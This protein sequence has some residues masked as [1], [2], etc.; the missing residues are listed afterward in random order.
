ML[1]R[2]V[3]SVSAVLA[4]ITAVG[5]PPV[6]A[7]H[8]RLRIAEVLGGIPGRENAQF[9]ELQMFTAGQEI[10]HGASLTFFDPA[11]GTLGTATF[12]ADVAV[13]ADNATVLA[14]TPQAASFFG[15][16]PDLTIGPL[17]QRAGGRIDYV[18]RPGST[19]D[20]IL[21]AFS[22]GS[23]SGDATG[24]GTPF[25]QGD[26][27]LPPGLSAHRDLSRGAS[28]SE[29]DT[30]DDTGDS[31]A[32]FFAGSPTPRNNAGETTGRATIVSRL[33]NGGIEVAA[34][35]GVTNLVGIQG[36]PTAGWRIVDT[37]APVHLDPSAL[38]SCDEVNVIEVRCDATA[39]AAITIRV[40]D[41]NDR[42]RVR[43]RIAA[44]VFG[45]AG[46]DRLIGNA[47]A[48]TLHG[49]AGRDTITGGNAADSV[50]AGD[51]DDT[52][53]V[54]GDAAADDVDCGAGEDTV[55]FDAGLDV[56]P[57]DGPGACETAN[58]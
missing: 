36:N 56:F 14:A 33:G 40:L 46:S 57:A 20:G 13:E 12:A 7:N 31:A 49:E 45:G 18:A 51:G 38:A 3:A 2:R 37:A 48:D 42:V 53:L 5:A 34:A 10:V 17:I 4:T 54:K 9:V 44:T 11:G 8:H 15:V 58:P 22:W 19:P 39:P 6:A 21:D 16:T 43:G 32:D 47:A 26:G 55:S 52:V 1:L 50:L 23:F 25:A 35:E 30:A 28:A 29:M 27:G 41:K 24:T